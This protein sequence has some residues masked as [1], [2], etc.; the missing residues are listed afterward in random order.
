MEYRFSLT[1]RLIAL[2][3]FSSVA[4]LILLFTLGY[5]IGLRMAK[6]VPAPSAISAYGAEAKE[7][8][9]ALAQQASGKVLEFTASATKPA[10]EQAAGMPKAAP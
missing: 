7:R 8:A 10:P 2:G 5:Q 6:P 9:A 3:L 4:L 1:P